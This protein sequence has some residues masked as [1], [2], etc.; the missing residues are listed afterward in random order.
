MRSLIRSAFLLALAAAPLAAANPPEPATP[1]A[2]TYTAESAATKTTAARPPNLE[3]QALLRV[4]V[5]ELEATI[6]GM[7]KELARIRE[8]EDA[9]ARVIGDPNDHKLWP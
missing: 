4:H 3:E 1:P 8:E 9:R 6:N 2:A 5:E 7:R